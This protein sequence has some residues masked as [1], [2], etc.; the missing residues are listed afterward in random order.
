MHAIYIKSRGKTTVTR[1]LANREVTVAKLPQHPTSRQ[2]DLRIHIALHL[3]TNT[4]H[5]HTT[6]PRVSMAHHRIHLRRGSTAP[7]RTLK[8]DRIL[9]MEV[10]GLHPTTD[11]AQ[12]HTNIVS[13]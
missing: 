10:V 6:R 1:I 9:P 12:L 5:L 8:A 13:N 3:L 7:H 4:A 11:I 2:M